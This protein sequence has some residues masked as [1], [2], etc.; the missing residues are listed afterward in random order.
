MLP[1]VTS[2]A[3]FHSQV[4]ISCPLL[5]HLPIEALPSPH[6]R[7][8]ACLN[9]NSC[10]I[11]RIVCLYHPVQHDYRNV[12]VHSVHSIVCTQSDLQAFTSCHSHQRLTNND[13]IT[14]RSDPPHPADT[15]KHR[16]F[17]QVKSRYTM[18]SSDVSKSAKFVFS[19]S[20]CLQAYVTDAVAI[21]TVTLR[22][23]S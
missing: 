20:S 1:S 15:S 11:D 22:Q 7:V 16:R 2:V 6:R 19:Y 18:Q 17:D 9:N 13:N 3:G 10:V 5:S 8:M 23:Q 21:H 4:D 12:A 14:I